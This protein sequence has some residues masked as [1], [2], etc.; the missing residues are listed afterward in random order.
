MT[1][2]MIVKGIFD[3]RLA[4]GELAMVMPFFQVLI[5]PSEK[6]PRF[7]FFR[8]GIFT[9]PERSSAPEESTPDLKKSK[10]PTDDQAGML[11]DLG[12]LRSVD[13]ILPDPLAG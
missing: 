9:L 10:T 8:Y 13:S 5:G 4:D 6:D 11:D 7:F 2:V 1:A 3:D 12:E